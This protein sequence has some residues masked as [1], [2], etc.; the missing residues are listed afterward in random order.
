VKLV[1]C[2]LCG[3]SVTVLLRFIALSYIAFV[4][5]Y[6]VNDVIINK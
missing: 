6:Y 5:L 4:V 1:Y 3:Y 2:K